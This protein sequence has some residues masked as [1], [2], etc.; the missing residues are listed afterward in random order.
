MQIIPSNPVLL[1]FPF[2][3]FFRLLP[4]FSPQMWL[5]AGLLA[6]LAVAFLK[7]VSVSQDG[8]CTFGEEAANW[9]KLNYSR[10]WLQTCLLHLKHSFFEFYFSLERKSRSFLHAVIRLSVLFDQLTF[11]VHCCKLPYS[12]KSCFFAL[13]FFLS[14]LTQSAVQ[15]VICMHIVYPSVIFS[16]LV[17]SWGHFWRLLLSLPTAIVYSRKFR[18]WVHFTSVAQ[19]CYVWQKTSQSWT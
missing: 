1:L 13:I 4:V 17:S 7:T 16:I 19:E 14:I 10:A 3:P 15:R 6:P 9:L 8:C 18:K 5:P 11:N 12:L 2:L